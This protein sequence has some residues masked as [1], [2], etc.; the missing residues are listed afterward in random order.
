MSAA[1]GD[2]NDAVILATYGEIKDTAYSLG[3]VD[4]E[5]SHK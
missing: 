4:A 3:E 1:M 2:F 5:D